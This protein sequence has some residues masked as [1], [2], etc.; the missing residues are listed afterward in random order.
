MAGLRQVWGTLTD[1]FERPIPTPV[2]TLRPSRETCEKC[3]W[4]AKFKGNSMKI[5]THY[6]SDATSSARVNVLLMKEGGFHV[7]TN[8]SRGIHWHVSPDGQVRYVPLDRQRKRIGRIQRYDRGKLTGEWLPRGGKK[9][10]RA[11]RVMDCVDCHNR[12]SHVFDATAASAVDREIDEGRLSTKVP[13]AR[14]V[15]LSVL[16]GASG[17]PRARARAVLRERLQAAYRKLHPEVKVTSAQL[18]G[19]ARGLADAYQ[20]NVYP[21]MKVRFGT[22]ESFLGHGGVPEGSRGCFRC[23]DDEHLDS[24]G[25]ALGR[26]CGRC[27]DLMHVEEK[28]SALPENLRALLPF[29]VE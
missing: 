9:G 24:K 10:D 21:E 19:L 27:H 5:L 17:I 2:E 14:H 29:P 28:P 4:P 23:H 15:A 3:H 26:D 13:W 22:Y 1:R 8:R 12:P 20:H 7:R 18:D 16:E 11:E 6:Q 25:K